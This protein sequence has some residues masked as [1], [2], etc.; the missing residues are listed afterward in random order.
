L[1]WGELGKVYREQGYII[2]GIEAFEK[3]YNIYK[4]FY[5]TPNHPEVGGV[6]ES[7]I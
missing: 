3:A 6:L 7:A 1:I 4:Q 2:R 5:V